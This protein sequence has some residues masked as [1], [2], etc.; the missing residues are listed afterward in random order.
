[1]D[2]FLKLFTSGYPGSFAAN[3]VA[4][5]IG[6]VWTVG[7]K[8]RDRNRVVWRGWVGFWVGTGAFYVLELV[9]PEATP[10]W[11][12]YVGLWAATWSL[13]TAFWQ[14]EDRTP[15]SRRAIF[16]RVVVLVFVSAAADIVTK[17]LT[18]RSGWHQALTCYALLLWAWRLRLA[19]VSKSTTLLAYGIVQLPLEPLF[20][21]LSI[22]HGT[23]YDDF[24]ASTFAIYAALKVTLIAPI[25]ALVDSTRPS[26]APSPGNVTFERSEAAGSS[27]VNLPAPNQST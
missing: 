12:P 6:L 8:G 22:P 26:E 25:Y 9:L 24:V 2:T 4:S 18:E 1:M 13:L 27:S 21:I 16:V 3:L 15:S 5:L 7:A 11:L 14:T 17:H 20:R 23:G 19:D 10:W